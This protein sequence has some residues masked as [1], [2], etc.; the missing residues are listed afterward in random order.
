MENKCPMDLRKGLALKTVRKINI[1]AT[2]ITIIISVSA[3]VISFLH[4]WDYR[5]GPA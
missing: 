2:N 3:N 5:H 4:S 1:L